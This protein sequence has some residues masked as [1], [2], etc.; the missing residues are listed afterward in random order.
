M[1]KSLHISNYALIDE[2]DINFH[3]GFNII[4]GETGAG[5]S[6]ILGALGLILGQRAD[7]NVLQQKDRKCTV[8]GTFQIK[9]YA[10]EPFFEEE[11][12]DYDD[13]TILRREITPAGKSRAFINDTPV[14][15]KVLQ[16]LAIRLIDIHSQHQNLEL[17]DRFFQLRLVDLVAGNESLLK[18]YGQVFQE[19]SSQRKKLAV[20]QEEADKAKADL[21]YFQ[22]QFQQLDEARLKDQEQEELEAEQGTLEHAEEIKLTFGQMTEDLERE[23]AGI[24]LRLKEH[25]S[26]ISKL[27]AFM[28]EARLIRERL[29][30]CY[31]ELKDL[32]VESASIAEHAE[33]DPGR[34]QLVTERL[35]LIYSLQQ[36]FRVGSVG[37]LIALKNE[38]DQKIQQIASFDDEI[39]AVS[40]RVTE[41]TALVNEQA[42]VI[43]GRRG[44]VAGLISES[45][46]EVLQ[47]LG[48]VNAIL[49]VQFEPLDEA[50]VNGMD[51]VRFLFS[52]NKSSVPLEISR[53]ASGGEIS[54]VMLALKT[55]ITDSKS[56]P[57]IVFDEIDTGIS[58]EVALKMGIILREMSSNMQVINITHLPQIAGKGQHHFKVYKYDGDE[59]TFTSIRQLNDDERVEELAL[60]L[61]GEKAS[62]TTRKTARELLN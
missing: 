30:S 62:E 11:E 28:P 49:Q 2:L 58:G 5:K 13:L 56:L 38:F 37:E 12:L 3:Q 39:E 36:K 59:R 61:G 22:F 9:D 26:Q 7:L 48:M 34:I 45:V 10:L 18:E 20:L 46:E 33:H 8:E 24:L 15:L 27:A 50:G 4:T 54:R 1:L 44:A 16:N 55:L 6:I 19:L 53:I 51:E 57:T 17:G 14:N 21:D 60:M 47:K 29:E 25:L 35:D 41:L 52:A 32:V 43:R 40:K 42:E 31:L 23:E